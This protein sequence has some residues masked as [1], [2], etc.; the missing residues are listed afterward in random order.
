MSWS[1]LSHIFFLFKRIF[2]WE[3]IEKVEVQNK[4]IYN[5][6]GDKNDELKEEK[7]RN[8]HIEE[9]LRLSNENIVMV[10]GMSIAIRISHKTSIQM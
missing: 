5:L 3:F 7:G 8:V 4:N 9:V 2:L 6:C 1:A 10:H